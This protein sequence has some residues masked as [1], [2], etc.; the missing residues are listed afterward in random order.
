[1]S[2]EAQTD[3]PDGPYCAAAQAY[4]RAGWRGLLPLPPR[5][6][7]S[8][9]RGWTGALGAF[10]SW[11]DVQAWSDGP[12]GDG[13]LALR[14][15]PDVIGL[16]VDAYSN[17]PGGLTL[18]AAEAA[19][20]P[21]PA[22]WR[23]TSRQDGVS[24]I[25]LFTVPEGLAWPGEL[26][27][28]SVD[29]IQHR[30]RYVVAPPSLH[31]S[32]RI[33]RWIDPE[34]LDVLGDVPSPGDLPDLPAAW[35]EGLTGGAL[36]TDVARAGLASPEVAAWLEAKGA[37]SPCRQ[38]TGALERT[39]R[40][41]GAPTATRGSRHEAA[42]R[43]TQRL[44]HL[45]AEGHPGVLVALKGA[46]AAWDAAFAGDG[47]REPDPGEWRRLLE[48]AVGRS[49]AQPGQRDVDPCVD[50][51]AGLRAPSATDDRVRVT[52]DHPDSGGTSSVAAPGPGRPP[53]EE[54]KALLADLRTWQHLPDVAHVLLTL[55][56]AATRDS[57]GEPVWLLLVA[58]PSSGKTEAVRLLDAAADAHLDDVSAAGLLG[59]SKGTKASPT[60][61]LTR[62]GERGLVTFGDLSSLLAM[63]DRGGRDTVFAMLRRAYDGHVTRDVSPPGRTS[64]G[65]ALT[66][67]GRLTVVAA[68]TG[69]IDRYAAHADALGPRWVY[70]RL[71][72]RDTASKRTATRMARAGGLAEGRKRAR[73]A[74]EHV[75]TAA[76]R[77]L[78]Q[79]LP[80]PVWDV[81]DDASLVTCWGRASVPR[82]GYGRREI[83][84]VPVTEEP[85][86]LAQQLAGLARGLLALGVNEAAAAA[87][88]R[89]VALD[90]MPASRRAVLTVLADGEPLPTAELA[91]RARL[92][93]RVARSALEELA[94]IGVAG[95]DRQHE[96]EDEPRGAVTW[97]L[98]GPNAPLLA[99][100]FAEHRRAAAGWDET[101][102]LT[103]PPPQGREGSSSL[104]AGETNSSSHLWAGS[105][106]PGTAE[107]SSDHPGS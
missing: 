28:G 98:D 82:S 83:T 96:D 50:P 103:P 64:S 7:A 62:I 45:A 36:V 90:S 58:A 15:P 30:H 48:G 84:D 87:L 74:A 63:S 86:R 41:L 12:D 105:V 39:R 88:V 89:R 72:E 99:S 91:R 68:V 54:L 40:E 34:G 22:S 20:G 107:D 6:K 27:G 92:D 43:G 24:G 49:A 19:W 95:N 26:P 94:A 1:M 35:V 77:C 8:V 51:L 93:R 57:T 18:A 69:V 53:V 100:V 14:L 3:Q 59:W 106:T 31:P 44:T 38:V 70:V 17:R 76:A 71:P 5:S 32:G 2:A 56:A 73:A 10:P 29:V 11:A 79:D 37:G 75:V 42:L 101:L 9:P 21:L 80:A 25:R 4:W 60:G 16:D 65:D 33:Y 55:A 97:T 47:D 23:S 104:E 85:M 13:N 81:I 66:W 46:R 67:R 61:V 78:P 52:T 102:V